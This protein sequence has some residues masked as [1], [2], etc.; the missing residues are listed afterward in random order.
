M[1]VEKFKVPEF[2]IHTDIVAELTSGKHGKRLILLKGGQGTGKTTES[3]KIGDKVGKPIELI[4]MKQDDEDLKLFNELN[5]T[6]HDINSKQIRPIIDDI[7][8]NKNLFVICDDWETIEAHRKKREVVE[9]KSFINELRSNKLHLTLI[10]HNKKIPKSLLGREI[11]LLVLK[12]CTI[13]KTE[14]EQYLKVDRI[15]DRVIKKVKKLKGHDTLYLLNDGTYYLRK[16]GKYT[17]DKF[18]PL[19]D[20]SEEKRDIIIDD[21]LNGT[22]QSDIIE[23]HK[24]SSYRLGRVIKDFIIGTDLEQQYKDSKKKAFHQKTYGGFR[25]L[26][27]IHIH[28]LKNTLT[29][30]EDKM[31]G[32]S[33]KKI[34]KK[35][36]NI[37]KMS[38]SQKLGDIGTHL[39]GNTIIDYLK[40]NES[41]IEGKIDIVINE[42]TSG[43]DVIIEYK[44]KIIE[45]E[46]KNIKSTKSKD[47]FYN[48]EL[49]DISEKFTSES[50]ERWLFT[51][52]KGLSQK[53]LKDIDSKYDM[54]FKHLSPDQVFTIDDDIKETVRA[55]LESFNKKILE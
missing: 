10:F 31:V 6:R 35:R 19:G 54:K 38:D 53:Y 5:I 8:K 23:T 41:S 44:D 51:F 34:V 28:L 43:S 42:Q 46:V 48:S 33:K 52:G 26:T 13:S 20:I 47:T 22:Q 45:I 17:K 16:D 12:S 29:L 32:L 9:S 21:L 1:I 30:D 14:L 27:G 50:T 25:D 39:V 49:E 40:E 3:C 37:K 7:K 4:T 36:K 11:S 24:V 15:S 2:E 55:E 18:I